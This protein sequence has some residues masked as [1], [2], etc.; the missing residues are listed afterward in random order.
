MV[1]EAIELQHVASSAQGCP[2]LVEPEW[3]GSS[4]HSSWGTG[5][6]PDESSVEGPG[7]GQ[8][9]QEGEG[10]GRTDSLEEEDLVGHW[11]ESTRVSSNMDKCR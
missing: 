11:M 3:A 5:A 6:E 1:A 8:T 9:A 10:H 2:P 7:Q 4:S